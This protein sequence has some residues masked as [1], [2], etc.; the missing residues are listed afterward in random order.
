MDAGAAARGDWEVRQIAMVQVRYES[1]QGPHVSLETGFY[2][3]LR[4]RGSLRTISYSDM[5]NGA[6]C[7]KG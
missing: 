2:G 4:D 7:L 3:A 5:P 1:P 6:C